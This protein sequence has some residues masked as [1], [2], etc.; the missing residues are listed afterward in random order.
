MKYYGKI[1]YAVTVE[2]APGIWEE[3][4]TERTYAG[5]VIRRTTRM[6]NN[7]NNLNDDLDLSNV[8]SIVAD[9]YALSHLGDIRYITWMNSKW[10]VSSV[11]HNPPRL[12]LTI[13]GVY[14]GEE[15][16]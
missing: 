8:M 6:Q 7:S 9:P 10:K 15:Q 11:E 16:T 3:Q 1:G 2:T 14:N 13:G 4:I 12:N 5:D